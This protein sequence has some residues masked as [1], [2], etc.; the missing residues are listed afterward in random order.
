VAKQFG[1]WKGGRCK[2]LVFRDGRYW[3]GVI[4]AP[5]KL[6]RPALMTIDLSERRGAIGI[7]GT[8]DAR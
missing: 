1:L 3:C 8:C 5:E 7:I 6:G 2:A 4:T